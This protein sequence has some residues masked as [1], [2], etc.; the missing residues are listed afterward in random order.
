MQRLLDGD[1][2]PQARVPVHTAHPAG[3]D[4]MP[5]TSATAAT[6]RVDTNR[7]PGTYN[8][9][10]PPRTPASAAPSGTGTSAGGPSTTSGPPAPSTSPKSASAWSYRLG[11]SPTRVVPD[12]PLQEPGRPPDP[13]LRAAVGAARGVTERR[14]GSLGVEGGVRPSGAGGAEIPS[15]S[16]FRTRFVESVRR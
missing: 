8:R 7:A 3:R 12:G 5:H 1:R 2:L 11:S 16:V 4:R 15:V 14:R 9:T 13:A 6:C 10:P